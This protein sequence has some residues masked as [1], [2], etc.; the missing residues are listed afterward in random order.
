MP[1]TIPQIFRLVALL[2]LAVAL[3]PAARAGE[4][5]T[6]AQKQ[7]IDTMIHDYLLAHPEVIIEALQAYEQKQAEAEAA[8]QREAIIRHED[9]LLH[10][11]GDPVGGNPQAS[12]TV[13]EFFDYKCPYCKSVADPFL[14]TVE[15]DGNVRIVFKEFPILGE[16]SVYAAR[17]ALAADK[18][19]KYVA[20]HRGLMALKGELSE[21][22]VFG[23]AEKV[24][25]DLDRL[26]VDMESPEIDQ[27]IARTH[28]LARA[29]SIRGTPAFIIGDELVPGAM[30]MDDL[31]AMLAEARKG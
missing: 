21:A 18:Q 28:E 7:A 16:S 22:A 31:K 3:V 13:V 9:A 27:Q 1:R 29:L 12:L 20:M 19:G 26:R 6:P 10:D 8:Q 14:Q 17:A 5:L 4:A 24:G 15:A 30:S 2:L 23:L 11:A 25:L